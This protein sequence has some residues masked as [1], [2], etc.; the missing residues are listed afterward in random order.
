MYENENSIAFR[1]LIPSKPF[2][3]QAGAKAEQCAEAFIL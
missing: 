2:L 1:N 3:S